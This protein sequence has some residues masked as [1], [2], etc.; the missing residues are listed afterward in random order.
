MT[1]GCESPH[2]HGGKL[3]QAIPKITAVI[4]A[5]LLGDSNSIGSGALRVCSCDC[6]IVARVRLQAMSPALAAASSGVHRATV[7]RRLG[8]FDAG[9]WAGLRESPAGAPSPRA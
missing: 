2:G 1:Q 9:G 3:G 6:E 8:R 5:H 4:Y 7:Y